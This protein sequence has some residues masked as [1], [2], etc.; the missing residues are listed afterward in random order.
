[1]LHKYVQDYKETTILE[2]QQ[3]LHFFFFFLIC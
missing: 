1:M 3:I 2:T